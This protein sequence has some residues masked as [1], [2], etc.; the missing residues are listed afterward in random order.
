LIHYYWYQGGRNA[1][2]RYTRADDN[3]EWWGAVIAWHWHM[4]QLMM[5]MNQMM[6]ATPL[7]D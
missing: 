7:Y 2:Q 1:T 4:V 3:D 5:I 6:I